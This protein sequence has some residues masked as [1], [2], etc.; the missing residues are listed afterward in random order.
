MPVNRKKLGA[1]L[2]VLLATTAAAGSAA[3]SHTGTPGVSKQ[4]IVIGGTF[5]YTGPAALYKT[6]PSAEQAFYAYVNAKHGGVHHR[7]IKDITLDDQY[8]P[9]QTPAEVKQLVE[10]DHVFAIVGSLG[11]APVLSTWGYLNKRQIPQV[12]ARHRRRVLGQLRPPR[13]RGLERSRGRWAGSRTTRV[14]R[15]STRSTSSRT[16][17][18]RRSASS[19]R[20]T[21]TARTT[22]PG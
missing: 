13:V 8:N 15:S 16:S 4:Q 14:R 19:T 10:K 12:L 18:T 1:L 22:S 9:A 21:P 7:K 20:T 5:P 17:R 3:A 6:I 11:T 2:F